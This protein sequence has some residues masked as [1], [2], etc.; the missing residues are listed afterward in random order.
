[1]PVDENVGCLTDLLQRL[2]DLVLAEVALAC[3]PR[4]ADM[5]GAECLRHRDQ[6][7]LAGVAV[8][9]AGGRV[10]PC[11]D[12]PEIL[13]D[14]LERHRRRYLMYCFSI[15]KLVFAFSALG[16]VGAILM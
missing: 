16:P 10:H 2:L 13:R 5:I 11:P 14:V 6:R 1:M 4:S 12:D 7:D 15:S 8:D 9:A 3:R